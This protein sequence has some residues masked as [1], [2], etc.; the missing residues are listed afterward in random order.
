MALRVRL[1]LLDLPALRVLSV[2]SARAVLARRVLLVP[3]AQWVL[4]ALLVPWVPRVFKVQ[5]E[6]ARLVLSVQL[7]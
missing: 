4:R 5:L 1:V 6:L 3:L 7:A 2:R